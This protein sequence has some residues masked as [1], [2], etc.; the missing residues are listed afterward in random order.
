MKKILIV[1]LAFT[2]IASMALAEK[3]EAVEGVW[4]PKKPITIIVPWAAGGSTDQST[5]VT[6]GELEGPLGQKI[7]IV[8][9]PGASGSVGTKS[10]LDAPRDG[11]T[12]TAGAVKDL[13]TYKVQG[14]LDT[15]L[16]D[17]HLFLNVAMAQVVAVNVN[18]PYK[19]FDDLLKAFKEKPGQITV[20][21]AGVNSAGHTAIELIKK[22]A[23]IEYKHVTYDG[24]NPA[25][26]ACVAGET[27]VVTQL[28]VEEVDMLRAGKLR[29][30][31]VL[32]EKP[33]ELKDYGT[34]PP[35]TKWIPDFKVAPIYFGIFVPKGVPDE[36][37]S[38][39]GNLWDTVIKKSQKIKD[40]ASERG[41][42]F[43]PSWG[44]EA[45]RKAFPMVQIDA[46]LKYDAGQAVINPE[47]IG[48]P[49]P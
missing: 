24:G 8:N 13:G 38:T 39:L 11:Y 29:A 23:G 34:I 18:T 33:L 17:W 20:A 49:R 45:Y 44:D 25:V 46:W 40:F 48:I 14:L 19:T 37:I 35:I 43:D 4:K 26:I 6:A 21:T 30:L 42:V 32:T 15:T 7:V 27:E 5:R 16:D 3:K 1:V 41:A 28:S 9:Q 10:C 36:V 12:W 47:E 22:Y 2:F 31:A